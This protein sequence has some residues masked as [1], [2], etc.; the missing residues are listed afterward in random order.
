MRPY[1]LK[2]RSGSA[3]IPPILKNTGDYDGKETVQLYIRDLTASMMRP[4]RE[5][6]KFKKVFLRKGEGMQVEFELGYEDL[7]FYTPEG[8]YLVECG[9]FSVFIGENCLTENSVSFWVTGD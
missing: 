7:G 4:I 8:T 1:A 9:E 2:R 5:L 6:K 3:T